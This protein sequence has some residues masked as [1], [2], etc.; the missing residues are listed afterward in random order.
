MSGWVSTAVDRTLRPTLVVEADGRRVEARLEVR[1]AH[2]AANAVAAL[3]AA[4]AAG[5]SLERAMAGLTEATVSRWRMEVVEAPSGALVVNDAYNANPTSMR[6]ALRALGDLEAERRVAV[7]GLMAELGDE[8]PAEHR[9]VVDEALAAGIEVVAVAAPAYGERA[10]HVDDRA[11]A[12]AAL[13]PVGEGDAVLVKGSRV[14]ELDRLAAE[15]LR[16]DGG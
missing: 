2:M 3:A 6:A 16:T 11:G 15:L 4:R 5:V 10:R 9:A 14:A 12:L 13:G 8:G 7:V 1:G